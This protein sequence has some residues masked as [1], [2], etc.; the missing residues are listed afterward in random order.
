MVGLTSKED[1]IDAAIA[2]FKGELPKIVAAYLS[3]DI[4]SEDYDLL[5]KVV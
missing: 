3:E 5:N 1:I 2:C 4:D